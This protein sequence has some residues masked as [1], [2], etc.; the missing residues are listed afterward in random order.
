M[1]QTRPVLAVMSCVALLHSSARAADIYVDASASGPIH[2]GTTWCQ[3]FLYLHHAL[4]V[5][6]S[7]DTILVAGGT[8]R[9]Y[10]DDVPDPRVATFQLVSGVTIEGGHAGCGGGPSEVTILSGDLNGDDATQDPPPIDDNAYHV[11]TASGVGDCAE[12]ARVTI[13]AGNAD[14]D[15]P[16]DDGAGVYSHQGTVTY[17]ECTFVGNDATHSG[18]ACMLKQSESTFYRCRFF[19]N[20]GD[21]GGGALYVEH[22]GQT[23][24]TTLIN[25]LFSG[26]HSES[27]GG[28]IMMDVTQVFASNC[29]FTQNTAANLGGAV[30]LYT[31]TTIHSDNS[32]FWGNTD[33]NGEVESSQIHIP[34]PPHTQ[35]ILRF[36]C[37]KNYSGPDDGNIGDNPQFVDP[38]GP[39]NIPGTLDDN[40]RLGGNSPCVDAGKNA[41][42][43]SGTTVD[44]DGQPRIS[45]GIVDMGA[46]ELQF[47]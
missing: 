10:I 43:P 24:P 9:P 40:A 5:A 44:L 2:N 17:R 38:N 30:F 6:E 28:A 37:I 46:Y 15:S 25:C 33:S 36:S 35:A 16:H 3:A 14:G 11:V 23:S 34:A 45:N 13:T 18:G 29:T 42:I 4:A 22:V 8:Y 41:L 1:F 20:R 39:D 21:A 26:N 19:A 32:I 12:L 27:N 47:N 31:V 7:G